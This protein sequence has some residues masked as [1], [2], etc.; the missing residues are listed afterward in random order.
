MQHFKGDSCEIIL[1]ILVIIGRI[2]RLDIITVGIIVLRKENNIR[3]GK[4]N[5]VSL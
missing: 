4:R 1:V 2:L 5:N 3:G